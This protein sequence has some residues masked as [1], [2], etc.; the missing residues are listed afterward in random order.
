MNYENP[1][2]STQKEPETYIDN[3]TTNNFLAWDMAHVEKPYR[4]AAVELKKI[5]GME[6]AVAVLGRTAT[7]K[8]NEAG[9]AYV[10]EK[11]AEL[12]RLK[13]QFGESAEQTSV[14][15]PETESSLEQWAN[16]AKQTLAEK[17]NVSPEDFE[18]MS[19]EKDGTTYNAVVYTAANG[20]DL[21][22]PKEDYDKARSWNKVMDK[23]AKNKDRH[24]LTIDGIE[25]DDR[26]GMTYALYDQLVAAAKAAERPLPDS[27]DTMITS[28]GGDKWY[29]WT[30]MTGEPLTAGGS[31]PF[32]GVDDDGSVNRYVTNR[33]YDY[34][35][36]LFR[37]AAIVSID[38][39]LQES[40]FAAE[41]FG[42]MVEL[43]VPSFVQDVVVGVGDRAAFFEVFDFLNVAG[44]DSIAGVLAVGIA[45]GDGA[46]IA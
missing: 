38:T 28:N 32:A 14:H 22:N 13:G 35:N 3:D 45:T 7:E 40:D 29:S 9:R 21:G 26:E 2:F 20:I 46:V 17:Y 16:D 6:A 15:S 8:G 36:L 27:K 37:P 12:D 41:L 1:S 31:A 24:T 5:P 44:G 39:L 19:Y 34:R 33:G 10:A 18:L 30:M 11:Q 42:V 23:G 25:Y 4:D 43:F